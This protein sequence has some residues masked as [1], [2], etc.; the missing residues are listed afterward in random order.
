MGKKERQRTFRV[1]ADSDDEIQRRA[2]EL[3]ISYGEYLRR[4]ALSASNPPPVRPTRAPSP[5]PAVGGAETD[6]AAHAPPTVDPGAGP[7]AGT[8]PADVRDS[9]HASTGPTRDRL[10]SLADPL[11]GGQ[12]SNRR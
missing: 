12:R 5:T 4:A 3:G 8:V 9:R 1:D 7:G 11:R 10:D 6:T 2:S